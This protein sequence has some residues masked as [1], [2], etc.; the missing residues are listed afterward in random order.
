MKKLLLI[1]LSLSLISC[2][3]TKYTIN[4]NPIVSNGNVYLPLNTTIQIKYTNKNL[5]S[6]ISSTVSNFIYKYHKLLDN[7]NEYENINNIY[8]I[9][10]IYGTGKKIEVDPI[11]K[12]ALYKAI[13]L[14]IDTNGYFNPTTG[15]LFN[16]YKDK[17]ND[18]DTTNSDPSIEEINDG[19]SCIIEPSELKDYIVIDGNTIEFK[20]YPKCGSKVEINLG[21]FSKGY[22][23]ESIKEEI[24][25]L[26][27]SIMINAGDSSIISI[28]KDKVEF[29]SAFRSP[30]SSS[31]GT[32]LFNISN[33]S[34]SSSGSDNQYYYNEDNILRSHILNPYTGYSN[35]NYL[36]ITLMADNRAD[37]LDGLT[38]ALFNLDSIEDIEAM[39]N[40]IE[41]KYDINIDYAITT[42][43]NGIILTMSEG[44]KEYLIDKN[45]VSYKEIIYR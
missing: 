3:V 40:Y 2:S 24:N 23:L 45:S 29:T 16:Y 12:D 19:L 44:F 37:I 34:I 17:F 30:Y 41:I 8:S 13:E 39:I 27:T 43:D 20:Q 33:K 21:A 35:N 15:T 22:T 38:T 1:I 31:D 26:D 42:N 14:A 25:E 7:Y 32:L 9:N 28:V 10:Q 36:S 6:D 11:L 4:V 5:E 18:Y